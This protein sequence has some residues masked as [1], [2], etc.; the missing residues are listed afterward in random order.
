MQWHI[1]EKR[2][3]HNSRRRSLIELLLFLLL[4]ALGCKQESY[5]AEMS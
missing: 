3:P 2:N 5:R 1:N 4:S